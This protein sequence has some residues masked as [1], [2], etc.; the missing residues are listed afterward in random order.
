[1]AVHTFGTG[2]PGL[3]ALHGFTQHGGSFAEPAEL[4]GHTVMAP[5]LPGHG[6]TEVAPVTIESALESVAI[7]LESVG[8]PLPLL[9]YSQGGRLALLLALHRP[10]LVQRLI[11]VSA[12][13]G[14]AGA[15]ERASRRDLDERLAGHIEEVGVEAFID[16]WLALPMFA[17]LRNRPSEWLARDRALRIEN[18]VRGLAGAV[19]GMGQG[20]Q[21]YVGDRLS[22]VQMP[23]LLIAGALDHKYRDLAYQ[24]GTTLPDATP[25]IIAGAGHAVIGEHPEA[26]VATIRTFLPA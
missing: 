16:E 12:S 13:P 15:V 25:S 18:T 9:G 5:D 11:L 10:D 26:V 22:E 2:D 8:R 23:V 19:R 24:M 6:S 1:M 14:I 3:V 20:V 21:P 7:V 17:G 4:L